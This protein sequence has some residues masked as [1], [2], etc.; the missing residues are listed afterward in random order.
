MK[1]I[2]FAVKSTT[3]EDGYFQGKLL[4]EEQEACWENKERIGWSSEKNS[5]N[6]PQLIKCEFKQCY[7][8]EKFS[9]VVHSCKI[10]K[11]I[12]VYAD[13][14]NEEYLIGSLDF[15]S[16]LSMEYSVCQ[17]H[18][19]V[20]PIPVI[21]TGIVLR[22]EGFYKN[23]GNIFHQAHILSFKCFGVAAPHLKNEAPAPVNMPCSP[24]DDLHLDPLNMSP[25]DRLNHSAADS[26]EVLVDY[27][28]AGG[29]DHGALSEVDMALLS[30][31]V[32]MDILSET[33]K[34]NRIGKETSTVV[35][36]LKQAQNP[37]NFQD[38]EKCIHSVVEL[39]IRLAH[40]RVLQQQAIEDENQ[41]VIEE[42]D[43]QCNAFN[44]NILQLSRVYIAPSQ[45]IDQLPIQ[46]H[47]PLST[48]TLSEKP[49]WSELETIL[50]NRMD[51]ENL[52]IYVGGET[53][54]QPNVELE[55]YLGAYI[56]KLLTVTNDSIQTVVL[57]T[58]GDSMHSIQNPLVISKV[59][60]FILSQNLYREKS[61][62]LQH[63]V[64]NSLEAFPRL[65][66]E[67]ISQI[68][69][70]T[71]DPDIEEHK[72][73]A[74]S[75]LLTRF[76]KQN[77]IVIERLVDLSLENKATNK[78]ALFAIES[79]LL[80]RE[81]YEWAKREPFWGSL[82]SLLPHLDEY[83]IVSPRISTFEN[84]TIKETYSSQAVDL[85]LNGLV[86]KTRISEDPMFDDFIEDQIA[87]EEKIND[88][89]MFAKINGG[90]MHEDIIEDK[91]FA[92]MNKDLIYKDEIT[93][94]GPIAEILNENQ[95]VEEAKTNEDP[96]NLND[97]EKFKEGLENFN[98]EEKFN[99]YPMPETPNEFGSE[100][101][102]TKKSSACIIS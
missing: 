62:A 25:Q 53:T 2:R 68:S 75:K 86:E 41:S 94:E 42:L 46:K 35:H 38:V 52:N 101:T 88:D 89:Q 29:F 5:R 61:A 37:S 40:V 64:L 49:Q 83:K 11:R 69:S 60:Q 54:F 22:V 18:H 58:L 45:T 13:G 85:K 81:L 77:A 44:V 19:V 95:I 76:P 73:A 16:N 32:P 96:E 28:K 98:E 9:I 57:L 3:S 92:K 66:I 78:D 14:S 27:R 33:A 65:E 84:A 93:N 72:R 6:W 7:K 100:N 39:G 50:R 70:F 51:Y 80:N 17:E 24:L 10:P 63:F 102:T 74:C 8:I 90:P 87:E 36:Q 15:D 48:E 1:M 20:L 56:S 12:S 43:N 99:E 23:Q 82:I 79:L 47:E 30:I 31:G 59:V 34:N 91:R 67:I 55:D 4:E 21:G 26:F 71:S 97:E